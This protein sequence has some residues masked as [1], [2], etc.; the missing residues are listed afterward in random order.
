V[1][2]Y[3]PGGTMRSKVIKEKFLSEEMAR[4]YAAELTLAVE[5]LHKY[6]IVHR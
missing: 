4:C 5:F 6:G 3:M 2:D 1:M